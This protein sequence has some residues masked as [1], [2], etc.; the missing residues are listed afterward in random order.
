MEKEPKL[1]DHPKLDG[2]WDE[3]AEN[4]EIGSGSAM[5]AAQA[6]DNDLV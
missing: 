1:G 6:N 3:A 5:A 2:P 4:I